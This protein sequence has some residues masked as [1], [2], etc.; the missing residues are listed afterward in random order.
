MKAIKLMLSLVLA[1][2]G[3]TA[4]ADSPLTST[5]FADVYADCPMVQMAIESDGNLNTTLLN[6]LADKKS[7]V[8]QR[9]AVIN[10]L[11][12]D[13]DGKTTG[14]QLKQFL[15]TRFKAKNDKQLLK[16]L[17]AKTLVTLGY[18]MAMSN[19]FEVND[20]ITFTQ[21]AV[22]KN[23]RK[24]FTVDFIA[25]LVKAQY[26]LD[27]DWSKIYPIFTDIM[28][29]GRYKLD[30]RQGAIDAVMEYINLYKDE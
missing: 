5:H 24:S 16:K 19:Y 7:P 6:F 2:W 9:V 3:T 17:D 15:M 13:F 30:M 10:A 26:F 4:L 29:D 25:G 11:G 14:D 20:A 12:W 28:N 22:K 1:L 18:A 27:H 21:A 8:D 23:G